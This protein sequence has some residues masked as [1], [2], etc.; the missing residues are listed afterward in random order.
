[1]Q[2][3]TENQDM[4]GH[5]HGMG[6]G[7][8]RSHG[9]RGLAMMMAGRFGGFGRGEGPGDGMGGD[10]M[11]GGWGGRGGHR[12]GKRFAGE[13][14][15]AMVLALLAE[16]PRHG[17]DLIRAFAARSGDAYQPS[18]G[19]L[20]PLLTLLDEMGLI[21]AAEGEAGSKRSFTLTDAGRAEHEA[22]RA[23]ADGAFARLAA[24]ADEAGRGAG[25]APIRRAMLN[26]RTAAVQR[27]GR[28]PGDNPADPDDLAFRVAAILDEAA[29]KI[30]RL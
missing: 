1:M 7:C 30:E 13:E 28:N 20:Y 23:T 8:G 11:G 5:N 12:R 3:H 22:S 29:Q 6:H 18:P 24:M 21:T 4:F 14:L 9:R 15:K 25:A 10:G 2:N 17:Y 16:E 19:V 27:L 26:L